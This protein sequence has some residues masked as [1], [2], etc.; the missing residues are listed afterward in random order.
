MKRI[1]IEVSGGCQ[2]GAV[3]YHATAMLDNA[4]V[5]HCRMCQKAVGNAF[6]AFVAAPRDA[7]VFTRGEPAR[8]RS[9]A[10]VDRGFCA[11]CGTP[12]FYDHTP[13]DRVNLSIGSL[14]RPARFPPKAQLAV[15]VGL[16]WTQSLGDVRAEPPP[17]DPEDLAW[18]VA[19]AHTSRQH[20]D[21]DTPSWPPPG[22]HAA[23]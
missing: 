21:Q 18:L 8:F 3:R 14:D 7:L 13:G 10:H 6:A 20:P 12:L 2:C 1:P 5:C 4:H 23:D 17:T 15:E 19:I 22:R 9:S 16:G 11:A